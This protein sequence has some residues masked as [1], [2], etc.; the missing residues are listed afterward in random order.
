[1]SYITMRDLS[2]GADF[3]AQMMALSGLYAVSKKTGHT[4]A[5]IREKELE[6]YK[7]RIKPEIFPNFFTKFET[8]NYL[9]YKWQYKDIKLGNFIDQDIFCLGAEKVHYNFPVHFITYHYF[10]GLEDE[11]KHLFEF[12]EKIN[13]LCKDFIEAVK[14]WDNK[15]IVAVHFRR[16][17]YLRVSSLNLTLDYYYKAIKH[18]DPSEYAILLFSNTNEDVSWAEQNFRPEGFKIYRTDHSYV[19]RLDMC[20]MSMCDSVI[21]A[22]SSYSWWASFLNKNPNKKIICP[23]D[24]LNVPHLNYINGNYFPKEWIPLTQI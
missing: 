9:D 24:Y 7:I 13:T 6:G 15:K 11:I 16:G 1:M 3:G 21:M 4:P 8:I 5:I 19:D 20:L 17:D 10:Q 2:I 18:F 12:S 14:K 23:Y 22:N